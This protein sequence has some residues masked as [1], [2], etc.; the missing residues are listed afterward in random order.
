MGLESADHLGML[1]LACCLTLFLRERTSGKCVHS[2]RLEKKRTNW[3]AGMSFLR[4]R[5]LRQSSIVERERSES[6]ALEHRVRIKLSRVIRVRG[7]EQFLDSEKDLRGSPRVSS[8]SPRTKQE[9]ITYLLD[10][11]GGLPGL[12]L[13]QDREAD[14]AGGVDVGV[15]ERGSELAC[16][17]RDQLKPH[18]ADGRARDKHLGGLEG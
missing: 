16:S 12:L 13:V 7:V 1:S 4:G 10:R 2:E 15:E 18:T 3:Y 14:G 9:A 11:D 17:T 5:Q 6:D 8:S